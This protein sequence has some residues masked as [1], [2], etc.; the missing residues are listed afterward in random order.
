MGEIGI[1]FPHSAGSQ[2]P[3]REL[4]YR[5]P[6]EVARAGEVFEKNP[7]LLIEGEF[8]EGFIT[9]LPGS[10]D[11]GVREGHPAESVKTMEQIMEE[12]HEDS[13][14][15]M[16]A[17]RAK[18]TPKYLERTAADFY[19]DVD[20]AIVAAGYRVEDIAAAMG[21]NQLERI[22]D[23][24]PSIYRALRAEGYNHEDLIS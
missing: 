10:I 8:L 2:H 7:E 12:E 6:E 16:E 23:D 18:H 20:R 15:D 14:V 17:E 22:I 5:S 9:R 4:R 19:A 13:G 3:Q 24:L 21:R 11:R 1:S